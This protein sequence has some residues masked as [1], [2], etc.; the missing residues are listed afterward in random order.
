MHIVHVAS[1]NNKLLGNSSFLGTTNLRFLSSSSLKE[2]PISGL[3]V[4]NRQSTH[5]KAEISFPTFLVRLVQRQGQQRQ[6]YQLPGIE[7]ISKLDEQISLGL[8][9]FGAL[10]GLFHWTWGLIL[11]VRS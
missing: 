3:P 2:L 10:L 5:H 9:P 4:T 8:Y 11:R 1:S 6:P 7:G